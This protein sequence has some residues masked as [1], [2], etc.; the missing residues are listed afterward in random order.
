MSARGISVTDNFAEADI[1]IKHNVIESSI[2][3]A[4]PFRELEAGFGIFSQSAFQH[5]RPGFNI[6]IEEN[7]IRLSKPNYCAITVAGPEIVDDDVGALFS[8]SIKNNNIHLNGGQ[9][10]IQ[11][12]SE[13]FRVSGNKIVGEAYF[14][15]QVSGIGKLISNINLS[16]EIQK[17][18]N[19]SG[20]K[21]KD[22]SWRVR[23]RRPSE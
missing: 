11:I 8:G 12:G 1:S 3:G 14:G 5:R 6:D 17:D 22:P 2:K 7:E 19:L 21:I 16:K 9:A 20:L 18:N 10:G 4:Y 15:I 23:R 13:N